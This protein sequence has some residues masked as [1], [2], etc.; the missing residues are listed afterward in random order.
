MS[1][2]M[3]ASSSEKNSFGKFLSSLRLSRGFKNVSEYLRS[4]PI[5]ISSVHYRHLESGERNISIEA[6]KQLCKGLQAEPKAFYFNLLNDWLPEEI[7]NFLVPLSNT[8]EDIEGLYRQA[9]SQAFATQILFPSNDACDYLASHFDL[10]AVLWFIYSVKKANLSDIQELI[11][12]N[13]TSLTA[14]DIVVEFVRLGLIQYCDRNNFEEVERVRPL[15]SFAHHPI[16]KIVLE[17]EAKNFQNILE[18]DSEKNSAIFYCNLVPMTPQSRQII[19]SRIREFLRDV[20]NAAEYSYLSSAG[21]AEPVY[22]SVIYAP[23]L[24][25]QNSD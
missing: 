2:L 17:H 21:N 3:T 25:R 5:G 19:F 4:Y 10:M 24:R 20:R 7:L 22:Y 18:K 23:R 11:S 16:G 14:K 1:R 15:I 8:Q 13:S 9:V 12:K 6:A